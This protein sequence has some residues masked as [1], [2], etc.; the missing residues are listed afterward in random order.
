MTEIFRFMQISKLPIQNLI[1]STEKASARHLR[2]LGPLAAGLRSAV[3]LRARQCRR[4][5][6]LR[7]AVRP[8]AAAR[9]SQGPQVLQRDGE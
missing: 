5:A 3:E 4:S 7:S 1:F 9:P 2:V 8:A 6:Q